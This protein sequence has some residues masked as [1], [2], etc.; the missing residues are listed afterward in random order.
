MCEK[1][2][3]FL[4]VIIPVYNG[5]HYLRETIESVLCQ[6]CNDIELL[7]I[8]DGSKDD[9][10]SICQS[11][12][13]DR[14]K[15]FSHSN[16]GVSLTRNEGVERS[17]GQ[18]IIFV[19]QDDAMRKDFYTD[20][21]KSELLELENQQVELI[22]PGAWWCDCNLI[23]GHRRYIEKE[24]H[25]SG[26]CEGR[27]DT[28]SWE[29]MFTFNMCLYSRS[30][31]FTVDGASTPVRFF[32]LKKDVETTFRHMALYAAQKIFFSDNFSFCLRRCNE[33]SVSSTWDWMQVYPVVFDAYVRLIIWHKQNYPKDKIA[34]AG[35]EKALLHRINLT[36]QEV[37]ESC[38]DNEESLKC[39]VES[40]IGEGSPWHFL[41]K[42]YPQDGHVIIQ[43]LS[44]Q[45]IKQKTYNKLHF[46]KAYTIKLFSILFEKLDRV[47]IQNNIRGK[48]L[49]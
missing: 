41:L 21:R 34:I 27:S 3:P 28:L 11:Y 32:P 5:A 16:C 19:D 17:K 36:I 7:L 2:K 42:Q 44:G 30:L 23:K 20:E 15:V 13:S 37:Y 31:F 38:R 26:V 24:A 46:I 49:L 39:L 14:V 22:V 4:S 25:C 8:D 10:L 47:N 9:S 33:E 48:Y 40:F 45:K 6:P 1:M 35:A 12:E 29:H 18:W 43:L